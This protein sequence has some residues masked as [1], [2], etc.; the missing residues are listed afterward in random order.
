MGSHA[1]LI[2][3]RKKNIQL[4]A[5]KKFKLSFKHQMFLDCY[6]FFQYQRTRVSQQQSTLN[7][8]QHRN[9]LLLV[10]KYSWDSH[11]R[12]EINPI[13]LKH[14]RFPLARFIKQKQNKTPKNNDKK[15][16]QTP[17]TLQLL[18]LTVI[19]AV[20]IIYFIK[21]FLICLFLYTSRSERKCK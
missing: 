19:S 12:K 9:C 20:E 5:V 14:F 15:K 8:K 4:L 3:K 18:L 10:S 16:R 11:F 2:L 21:Y 13:F 17:P 7:L 1:K 6:I